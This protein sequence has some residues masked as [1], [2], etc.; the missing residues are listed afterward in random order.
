VF[1]SPSTTGAPPARETSPRPALEAASIP[2]LF[3]A[4]AAALGAATAAVAKQGAAWREHSWADL[5]RRVRDVADGLAALGVEHGDRVAL[6][7]QTRLEALVAD[8]G[9]MATGAIAVPIYQT[10]T[11]REVEHAL[12]RSGASWIFCED[13]EQLRKVREIRARL[14]ALRGVVP[15]EGASGDGTELPLA[16][17]EALGRAHG[18]DHPGD[19][20][21]RIAGIEP[22]DPASILWTS[23]TT[24]DPKGVVLTHGGWLHAGW[25]IA[26]EVSRA[27]DVTLLFLPM[28][29]SFAKLCEFGWIQTGSRLAF[30]ES[31]ERLVENAAEV[32]PTVLPAPPR[33]Y[34]KMFGAVVARGASEPGV[35]GRLF[36]AAMASFDR[37]SA[38]QDAGRPSTGGV[39]LALA[40]R[41]VFPAVARTLRA[42]LGGRIRVLAS[43]SAPLSPRIS[44][45]FEAVGLPIL[46][47]YGLTECSALATANRPGRVR[48]GTV[49][50]AVPGVDLRIAADGEILVRGP[51]L[52]AGYWQDPDATAEMIRD[53]WLHT[54]DVGALDAA[55]YLRITDRKKDVFKTSG[56]KMVAPQA[57]EK[58]L[59]AAE[60]LVSHALVHGH[61]RRFV[62]ALV[63][64]DPAAVQRWAEAERLTLA[65]PWSADARVR[66]RIQRAVDAVNAELPRF[67]TIKRFAILPGDFSVAGGEL[68]PTMKLRRRFV[69][70]RYRDVLDEL[71][72]ERPPGGEGQGEGAPRGPN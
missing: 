15:L 36:R 69:E 5:A 67:A 27:D 41:V 21:E 57:L 62:T 31:V 17:L 26:Q 1:T 59:K 14:P 44:R 10:S 33:V 51:G 2:A 35:R 34:E 65:R 72:R 37:W 68:T 42:R 22:G 13:E 48:H 12:V 45:F 61:A 52:M 49:G 70:E 54:G 7:S 18:H 71:Y 28:A 60:P 55:G 6:L 30:A 47:G 19:H 11:A 66:A 53:G 23:G 50:P 3:E 9:T 64:L 46:E 4:R 40:R 43:G 25:A 32:R 39:G 38:A 63:A 56:G 16:A 58:E 29:H 20:A 24:G 8:L